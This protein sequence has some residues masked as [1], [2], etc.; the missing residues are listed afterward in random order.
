[1][2]NEPREQSLVDWET[3]T[4]SHQ[5]PAR[6]YERG[7]GPATRRDSCDRTQLMRSAAGG[8]AGEVIMTAIRAANLAPR[9]RAPSQN[10]LPEPVPYVYGQQTRRNTYA[11]RIAR[12]NIRGWWQ[13]PAAVP[14]PKLTGPQAPAATAAQVKLAHPAARLRFSR[15]LMWQLRR[16]DLERRRSGR[17]AEAPPQNISH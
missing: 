7:P 1:M 16:A 10:G 17:G 14:A 13:P 9:Q 8:I 4:P 15:L 12:R 6:R 3:P 2:P 5:R 11:A